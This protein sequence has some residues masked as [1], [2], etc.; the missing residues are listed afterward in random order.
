MKRSEHSSKRHRLLGGEVDAVTPAEVLSFTAR[1][2]EG[3]QGAIVANHNLHSLALMKLNPRMRDF[4]ARADLIEIDSRPLIAWGRLLGRDLGARHRCTYLDWRDAFWTMA[5]DRG[6]RVFYLGGEP[7]V[8]ER[9]AEK[10][11][12]RSPGLAL[13]T[14]HGYFDHRPGSAG[15]A[16]VLQ[17]IRAFAPD[18]IFVGMGMPIQEQWIEENQASLRGVIFPVGA[19][20]DYEAGA[21]SACPRWLGRAGLEWLYRFA[22]QPRR[23]F[24]RYFVEPWSLAPEALGDLRDR[25]IG[26][27]RPREL[28][29]RRGRHAALL[30][31]RVLH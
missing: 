29:R 18:V 11:Q 27:E 20:F 12:A 7:G 23:L 24:H 5:Q 4:Y 19:A 22:T 10:I 14:H 30:A 13:A 28:W 26:A 31:R 21:Q 3:A 6:W 9:A 2:I 1:R 17:A 8:A 16:R 25:L 15:T